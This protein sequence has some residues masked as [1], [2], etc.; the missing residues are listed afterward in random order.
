MS[1]VIEFP[2]R[3][4]QSA[5]P[6]IDWD[7]WKD[8]AA[9]VASLERD[10]ERAALEAAEDALGFQVDVLLNNKLADDDRLNELLAAKRR[11]HRMVE[12]SL[13]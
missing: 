3:K 4:G 11:I 6:S 12:D 8:A 7:D 1:N 13:S 9:Q 2:V 10:A 5:A